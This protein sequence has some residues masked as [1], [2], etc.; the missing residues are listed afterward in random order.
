MKLSKAQAFATVLWLSLLVGCSQNANKSMTE[1][2]AETSPSIQNDSKQ[3]QSMQNET[4]QN[5]AMQEDSMANAQVDAVQDASESE[6]LG[7]KW[8]DNVD[9]QVTSVDLRRVS[10]EP[11][12]QMQISYADKSYQGRALNSR[13]LVAGKVD[14]SV[15]T[16]T[17]TLPLY[18]NAGNYYL[19]GKSGEAYRLVYRNN[20]PNTYEI[21]ATVDGLNVLDGSTGSRYDDGYVLRPNDELVIEGFRKSQ[22]AV[23]SFIFSKP[24]DSYAA[25]TDSG[26][27]QNTGVIGTVIYELYDPTESRSSQPQAFPADEGYA[28]SPQ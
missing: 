19:Q 1:E 17:G 5:E 22:D 14:F 21:V 23:A 27:I 24:D 13:S 16:D 25:N 28:K 15:A 20:S 11:I 10:A 3:D 2:S 9:S 26:S 8:G 18:R 6:R 12:E 4:M 7:T